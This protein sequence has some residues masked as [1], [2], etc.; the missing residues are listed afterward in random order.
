MAELVA[1]QGAGAL[2]RRLVEAAGSIKAPTESTEATL[3][4]CAVVVFNLS[5]AASGCAALRRD[6]VG[7]RGV[8]P[9][10]ATL[11]G[12][13]WELVILLGLSPFLRRIS[14]L[15]RYLGDG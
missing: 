3:Y 8:L 14:S 13:R 1:E 15:L 2:V 9:A 11:G 6:L 7:E 4:D 10:L 5:A 12:V